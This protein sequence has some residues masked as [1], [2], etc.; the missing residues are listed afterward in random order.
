M[1]CED[2]SQQAQRLPE[3][4]VFRRRPRRGPKPL[5]RP[6]IQAELTAAKEKLEAEIAARNV[7]VRH[8]VPKTCLSKQRCEEADVFRRS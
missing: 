8:V 1:L 3:G 2:L 7:G 4:D 5:N 6:I